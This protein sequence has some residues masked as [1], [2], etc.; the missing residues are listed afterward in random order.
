[1]AS[2]PAAGGHGTVLPVTTSPAPAELGGVTGL[3][4]DVIAA[5]GSVGVGLLTLVETVIPPIPSEIVLPLAGFLAQQGELSLVGV[6]VAAT[7]GSLVGAWFFYALGARLGLERAIRL[8][9]RVP[10]LD[11]EDLVEASDWFARHGRGSVFF[12][13]FV[14]G[15]RSLVSLPAGAQRM[16]LLTFTLATAA[17]SA[18]WN[19]LLVGA[20]Y[21]LGTQW[22]R[23]GHVVGVVSDVVL[24]GLAV[25]AVVLLVR[26]ARRRKLRR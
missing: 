6:V 21:A 3:F 14:P 11:R 5:V 19:C 12:G 4:A 25:L 18:L 16:D 15:V 23:V 7:L 17:G 9:S 26:R 1:M 2:A 13:R 24:V 22:Q 8:L 10:L 20:G